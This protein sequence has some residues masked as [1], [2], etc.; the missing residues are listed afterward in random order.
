MSFSRFDSIIIGFL[1]TLIILI[2]VV[3][4]RGDQIG[5]EVVST[6]PAG[7]AASTQSII[8]VTFGEPIANSNVTLMI[9]PQVEG[10][11]V[12]ENG[13]ITFNP[14]QPLAQETL[15]TVTLGG[16]VEDAQGRS[17]KEP[18]QWQF[19]TGKPRILF[20]SWE[21]SDD[22][23]NQIYQATLDGGE[24]ERLSQLSND[25]SDFV[26]SP[27]GSTILFTV[28]RQADGGSDLWQ[29]N[30]DGSEQRMA[31][32]C[33]MAACSQAVFVPAST[34]VIYERRTI[35][36][37]GAPPGLPRLWWFDTVS[38]ETVPL[39]EDSQL[40]G[41]GATVSE[42]GR[43][44]S[45]VSPTDQGIQVYSLVDGDGIFIPNRM[46]SPARWNPETGELLLSD[47]QL[48]EENQWEVHL[49]TVDV[50]SEAVTSLSG[51]MQMPVD[52]STAVYSPDGA[53]IAFG[54]KEPRT[55]M[56][57]QL[58]VMNADGSNAYALTNDPDAH[59]GPFVWSEDG[60]YLV[61]QQYRLGE[62][63]AQPKLMLFDTQTN[64][65]REIAT[66]AVQPFAWIP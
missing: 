63:F 62:Q 2:A 8:G 33:E 60:R 40:L 5:L 32:D 29:M 11:T 53:F 41:L 30:A 44:L 52:D 56:G 39:F 66:P 42:D 13:R 9:E 64:D 46:G 43:F 35:P 65:L 1:T 47:I 57:R 18:V 10:E 51:Q 20:I 54:R 15:Y 25:I 45:F 4:V 26:V 58:W 36:S 28:F 50:A 12:V 16:T 14:T 3:I 22:G 6:F 38:G 27:D 61:M 55:A 31:L 21:D 17:L 59:H 23:V 37:P 19:L 24:P 34:R 7:S 49:L 48:D